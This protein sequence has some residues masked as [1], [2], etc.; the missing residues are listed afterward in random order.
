MSISTRAPS[1]PALQALERLAL[2]LPQPSVAIVALALHDPESARAGLLALA[3]A[4]QDLLDDGHDAD[5][6]IVV[7]DLTPGL[8]RTQRTAGWSRLAETVRLRSELDGGPESIDGWFG[9]ELPPGTS[10]AATWS[11][12][13]DSLDARCDDALATLTAATPAGGRAAA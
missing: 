4:E 1:S 11:A 6:R 5:L 12:Q 3:A 9:G 8:T 13:V 7:V 10:Q 2:T